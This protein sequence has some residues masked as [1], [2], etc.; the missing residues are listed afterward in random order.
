MKWV[1]AH[2]ADSV[3]GSLLTEDFATQHGTTVLSILRNKQGDRIAKRAA[4]DAAPIHPKWD[5]PLQ[6]RIFRHMSSWAMWLLNLTL[7]QLVTLMPAL[8]Q[9]TTQLWLP[10][11]H[12]QTPIKA[13]NW[14][15][16]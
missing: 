3:P 6:Q 15:R 9:E 16:L 13:C 10:R 4:N 2:V 11:W 8:S 12:W 7:P 14:K 1:P 5:G